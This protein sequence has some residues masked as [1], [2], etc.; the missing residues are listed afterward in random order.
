MVPAGESERPAGV[1]RRIEDPAPV[2]VQRKRKAQ[3]ELFGPPCDGG[4]L[5]LAQRGRPRAIK[6]PPLQRARSR[7]KA[8]GEVAVEVD[9]RGIAADPTWASFAKR[10][11]V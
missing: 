6:W 10:R 5:R 2:G 8:D 4:S 3:I 11:C 1:G 7:A 9:A